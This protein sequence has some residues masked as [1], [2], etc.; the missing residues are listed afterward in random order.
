MTASHNPGGPDNDFGIKFNCENGGPAPDHV[1]DNIYK[2]STQ[3]GEYRTVDGLEIDVSKIGANNYVVEGKPFLVEII[4][5][6]ENYVSLMRSIFDFDVLAKFVSGAAN[7]KPLKM[8]IDSMNGG[9]RVFL[10]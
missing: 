2:L 10:F 1:T 9:M 8:R 7:G 4:D 6:T 3:I 5:S